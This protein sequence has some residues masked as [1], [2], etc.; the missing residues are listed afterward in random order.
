MGVED[1]RDTDCCVDIVRP[2]EG[3][4]CA[5]VASRG[6]AGTELRS[7][8]IFGVSPWLVDVERDCGSIEDGMRN[9]EVSGEQQRPMK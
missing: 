9:A 8:A 3:E 5:A 6:D 7:G 1:C 4:G 2:S